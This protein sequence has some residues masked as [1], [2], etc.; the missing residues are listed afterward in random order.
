M[1]A[2]RPLGNMPSDGDGGPSD[3]A[4]ARR[5]L[6][7]AAAKGDTRAQ[8]MLADMHLYG[9]HLRRGGHAGPN[10]NRTLTFTPTLF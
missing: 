8:V 3:L 5:L 7:L 9:G 2:Y 4:E 6:G 1:L 10:P